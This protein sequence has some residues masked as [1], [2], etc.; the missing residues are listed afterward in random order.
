MASRREALKV[1]AAMSTVRLAGGTLIPVT[2]AFAQTGAEQKTQRVAAVQFEPKLGDVN[3][4]LARAEVLVREALGKGAHWIVLPEFFPTGTA[5]HPVLFD[6][7]QPLDGRPMQMLKQL[8]TTGKAYVCGSFMARS[9]A[10]AYN[11]MV[12]ACPDGELLTHDKDYPTMIFESAFYAAGED[13]TYVEQLS[14]AGAS[15]SSDRIPARAANTPDGLFSHGNRSIGAAV[16]WE[17]VR[18]RTAKRLVGKVDV[19][20]ASSGWWTADPGRTWPGL[21]KDQ[22]Q[23]GWNEHQSLIDTAPQRFARMIGAPVIHANFT[24]PN[25]GFVS[26]SFDREANGRY[27]GSSQIVDGQGKTIARMGTEEGVLLAELTLAR[28]P[29]T[30]EITDDFWMQEVSDSMRRR[31]ATTGAVGRDHYIK[32]TRTRLAR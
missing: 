22:A 11:T 16:C 4:N 32:S 3:V 25:P 27:L 8:A 21:S 1:I 14:K 10:D 26:I 19:V 5:M 30:E 7:Y 31:W 23:A 15:T 9:G 13:A 17:I 18:M 20:V 2:A 6:S 28:T 24:G 29:P 12:V